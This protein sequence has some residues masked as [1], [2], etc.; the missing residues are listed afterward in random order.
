M[1][2]A[3]YINGIY[4]TVLTEIVDAQKKNDNLLCY[5][6]PYSPYKI[7]WKKS[8]IPTPQ[9][10]ISLYIST[11]SS[12]PIVSYKAKIIGWENKNDI[13]KKRMI[14]LNKHIKEFQPKETEIYLTVDDGKKCI[15][16]IS[17]IELTKLQIPIPVQNFLKIDD[18][19]PLKT[20]TRSGGWSYVNILPDWIE[21]STK[22]IIADDYEKNLNVGINN[23]RKD[24]KDARQDRLLKASKMPE[25]ILKIQRGY[26][27]NYDVIV[28]VLDRANG[29]CEKCNEFAPFN[30]KSD[31]SPYLEVHHKIMLSKGGEDTVENAMAVCP[32]CHKELHYGVV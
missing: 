14:L 2:Y 24:S 8:V 21:S 5:L 12:L 22:S 20:R 27:R 11:T 15:N 10:P 31:N 16:L 3:L 28:S 6:Q 29:I 23:S 26:N 1:N 18:N 30:R 17:V 13:N 4:E 25:S 9:N 19:L 7:N 32:N